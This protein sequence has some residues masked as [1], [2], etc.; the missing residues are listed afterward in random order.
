MSGY[1]GNAAQLFARAVLFD[2]DG[3]LTTDPSGS[4][5]T[6]AALARMT[7]LDG[8]RI[9]AALQ[10]FNHDL[11]LGRT[12]HAAI[13]PGFCAAI[14]QDVPIERLHDAFAATPMDEAMIALARRL[15]P[16]CRLAI[17]TDNKADRIAHLARLHSLAELFDVVA[18][19]AECGSDKS[20]A[21]IFEQVL[22]RLEVPANA[23]VFIDNSARNL[24][25]PASMGIHTIL[26]DDTA[27]DLAALAAQLHDRFALPATDQSCERFTGAAGPAKSA[28]RQR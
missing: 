9:W 24:V 25:A 4:H 6:V 8:D 13:W 11:L 2:F 5:T 10:P 17:V 18:V 7:G 28:I 20:G 3:V 21:P 26:F 14:G 12:T 23:A 16:H 15:R 1:G 19:S 27:R 22:R